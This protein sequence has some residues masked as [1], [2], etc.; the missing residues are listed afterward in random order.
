MMDDHI[1]NVVNVSIWFANQMSLRY[2]I[3]W[4]WGHI[5]FTI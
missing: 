3:N 2:F 1:G 4:A 5:T